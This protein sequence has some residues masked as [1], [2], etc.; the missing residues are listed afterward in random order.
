MIVMMEIQ[1]LLEYIMTVG[2]AAGPSD[3]V[4]NNL[5]DVSV[6]VSQCNQ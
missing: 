3:L 2:S 1:I 5:N 6:E 4:I